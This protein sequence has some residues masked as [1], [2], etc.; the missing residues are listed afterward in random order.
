MSKSVNRDFKGVWIPKEIWLDKK[1]SLQ[2]KIFLVEIDSLDNEKGCFA[3]NEY[4]AEFFQLSKDRCSEVISSL[5]LKGFITV[6]VERNSGRSKRTIRT[7][8]LVGIG[9]STECPLGESPE[10]SNTVINNKINKDISP[11]IPFEEFWNAYDKKTGRPKSEKKWDALSLKDQEAILEH[12]PKYKIA[13]P[14]KT[15]RK[16]P[17]TFFNNRSWEDELIADTSANKGM[18]KCDYG[19]MH[20]KGEECGHAQERIYQNSQFSTQL[21]DKFKIKK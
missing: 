14:N 9:E 20:K 13:Q 11:K 2:E 21:S 19:H 4:F 12:I 17:E 10:Y 18:W 6:L 8:R 15:Y 7:K 5:K 16:N 3:G 1:M